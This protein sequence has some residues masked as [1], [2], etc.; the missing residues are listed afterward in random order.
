MPGLPNDNPIPKNSNL[1]VRETQGYNQKFR[2]GQSSEELNW[3]NMLQ[4]NF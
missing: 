3:P 4:V 1:F 2:T